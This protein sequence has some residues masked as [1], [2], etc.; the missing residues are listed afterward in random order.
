MAVLKNTGSTVVHHKNNLLY[1][2][3]TYTCQKEFNI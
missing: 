2:N 1:S 3:E